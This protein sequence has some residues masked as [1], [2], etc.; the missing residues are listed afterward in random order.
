MLFQR[1]E[2]FYLILPL[3]LAWLVVALYARTRRR[4]AAAAFIATAMWP[5]LLPAESS[6]RFWIKTGLIGLALVLGVMALARPCF[7]THVEQLQPRGSDVYV[8]LDVS[9]SMLADD[10]PPSRLL[11]AKSDIGMLLN[12]LRGERIGLVAFAGKALVKCPLTSDYNFFRLMLNDASPSSV[13]RGGTAIG[14]AIRKALEVMPRMADRDQV[15]LLITDGEDQASYPLEAAAAA[16]E[17]QV[18][19]FTVGLGDTDQGSRIPVEEKG[20]KNFVAY[21]GQQVWSKMD[22]KLLSEI[23]LKTQ[24]VYIPA[25]TRAYDLGQL[26]DDHLARLRGA[27][28]SER[29]RVTLSEQYQLFLGL[30]LACLIIELFVRLY[31]AR[32]SAGGVPATTSTKGPAMAAV[33]L[34]ALWPLSS[35]PA[36]EAPALVREG[37][38]H[39][40]AGDLDTAKEKFSKAGAELKEL[41]EGPE[42]A[43]VA[44]DLACA[45][46]RKGDTEHAREN[47]LKAGL[48][49]DKKLA[50][51]AH[52]NLGCL[53][54]EAGR[55]LAGEKPERELPDKRQEIVDKLK[56][57]VV[58]YRNCL[59]IEPPHAAA[60][61]NIELIR[62]W[63]KLYASKWREADRRKMREE[64][65]LMQF[66]EYLISAQRVLRAGV[67][68]LAPGA[69][70]DLFAE[71]KQAQDEL[72]Q[73]IEPLKEKILKTLQPPPGAA[74]GAAPTPPPQEQI[75]EAL[76]LLQGWADEAGRRMVSAAAFLSAR[77]PS[78]SAAAQMEGITELEKIWEAIVPFRPLLARDL[79]DQT[80]VTRKLKPGAA[81]EKEQKGVISQGVTQFKQ[82]FGLDS[83]PHPQKP[84][85][86]PGGAQQPEQ[87][88]PGLK[89]EAL[90]EVAELQEATRRRTELL[91]EK[92]AME[93]DQVEKMPATPAAPQP[94]PDPKNTDPKAAPA[95]PDPEKVKA[96]L[97]KAIELAPKAVEKMDAALKALRRQEPAAAAP[98]AEEARKILEEIAK[99]Q[100]KDEQKKKDSQQD[101]KEQ[102]KKDEQK[103]EQDKKDQDKDKEE[104]EKKEQQKK[105]QENKEQEQK[106]GEKDEPEDS[107]KQPMPKEQVEALLRQIREREKERRDK[108]NE[109]RARLYGQAPVEKDW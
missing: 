71:R 38:E 66:L 79:A 25:R 48:A 74:G 39:F 6:A 89:G 95:G 91:R 23:A 10:V 26:Y 4:R 21:Q 78:K 92:A 15:L 102:D 31:P 62:Q 47:Y 17:R 32:D 61:K 86:N 70:L 52:F 29:K 45:F 44:F 43:V 76:K 85:E 41:K 51:A 11:R 30:A 100:P 72:A 53:L 99:E 103:Q 40:A 37:L 109:Q 59:D 14:D 69:P 98:D 7:G 82:T 56:E 8:L 96:G 42:H 87:K 64:T 94:L 27:A 12:R 57:A 9:R 16:A 13:P 1:A 19:I 93:L 54:A 81:I 55:T 73:E 2:A 18:A 24:G 36:G 46:H 108:Q 63:I 3:T 107:K 50:A 49:L 75:D 83:E 67:K 5:R 84:P 65:N 101:K 28:G 34:F 20:A 60:R 58:H 104:K 88:H 105:E 68:D 80:T 33:V 77:D 97:R 90:Q 22:G 106:D 35:T